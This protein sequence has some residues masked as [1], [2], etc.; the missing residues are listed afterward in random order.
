MKYN[1]KLYDTSMMLSA[2][3]A[4]TKRSEEI[5]KNNVN[6]LKLSLK[7]LVKLKNLKD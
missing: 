2:Y 4:R 5:L 3:T 7:D 6:Y 1:K